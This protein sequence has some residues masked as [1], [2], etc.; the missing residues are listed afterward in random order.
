M[1]IN[2]SLDQIIL[3]ENN[4]I[5]QQTNQDIKQIIQTAIG[6]DYQKIQ[7]PENDPLALF[8][9]SDFIACGKSDPDLSSTYKTQLKTIF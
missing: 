5:Q 6:L 3:D 2:T 9:Q 4:I 7:Q 8:K 1:N